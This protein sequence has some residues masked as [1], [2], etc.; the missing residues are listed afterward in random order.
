MS[1]FTDNLFQTELIKNIALSVLLLLGFSTIALLIRIITHWRKH[2]EPEHQSIERWIRYGIF[3]I[4][5]ILLI[6]IWLDQNNIHH[7]IQLFNNTFTLNIFK[8][9]LIL[10]PIQIVLFFVRR[11]INS[12]S[13][14]LQKK[15]QYRKKATL[16]GTL[17]FLILLIPLW[18]GTSQQFVTVLSVI[19]AG[20][21]L[22]LHEVLLNMAGWIYITLR[23]PFRTGDRIEL[24]DVKGDVIDIRLFSAILLEVGNW[25]DAEQSTGRVVNLPNGQIFRKPLY[26][27][28]KGF[29][30]IWNEFS[31][32]VTFESNW[33][34]AKAILNKQGEFLSQEIQG[35][36]QKKID[37]MA[38]KYLIYY[39][40]FSSIVYTK[41][42][43][44][45]VKLTLRYLTDAKQRRAG[46]DTI[47]RKV[48]AEIH[49][50]S[51]IEFAYPTIR[52]YQRSDDK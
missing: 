23:Q 4:Y 41:V 48:L 9:I 29:E 47:A 32:L 6:P 18:A 8:S 45:G 44:S 16:A 12:L 46:E 11:F 50:A 25:V 2:P 30:Y 7:F 17:L 43:E 36:V 21:A 10:I 49:Q 40:Q 34:A 19:G 26:N 39:K 13:L 37:R 38:R 28:T 35:E 3:I 52:Y 5:F 33:E 27:Y 15:H 42:E 31:I 24:G 22:A 20:I 14:P 1:E 51:D